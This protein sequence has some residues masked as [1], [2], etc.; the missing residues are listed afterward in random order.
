MAISCDAPY[1]TILRN[2]VNRT[3]ARRSGKPLEQLVGKSAQQKVAI[4]ALSSLSQPRTRILL[5]AP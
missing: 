5:L 2:R 1:E 3:D 4:V